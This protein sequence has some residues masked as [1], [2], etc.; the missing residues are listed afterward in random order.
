MCN[1][2]SS[3]EI[4]GSNALPRLPL[5]NTPIID[6]LRSHNCSQIFKTKP[7]SV[8]V[9]IPVNLGDETVVFLQIFLDFLSKK[10]HITLMSDITSSND[11]KLRAL[12]SSH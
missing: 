1:G 4:I 8:L 7:R 3:G 9:L 6:Y 5:L 12:P 2:L 11:E 10:G